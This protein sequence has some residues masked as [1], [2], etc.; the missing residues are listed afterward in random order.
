M[1]DYLG[2]PRIVEGI[3]IGVTANTIRSGRKNTIVKHRHQ[4]NGEW[5]CGHQQRQFKCKVQVG[6][7]VL[8]QRK[9]VEPE[10]SACFR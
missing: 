9:L 3:V 2:S 6:I 8:C 7:R 5:N 1:L 4:Q 10:K